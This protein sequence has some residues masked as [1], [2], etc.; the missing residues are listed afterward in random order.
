MMFVSGS[1]RGP[2]GGAFRGSTPPSPCCP[3]PSSLDFWIEIFYNFD[4]TKSLV[5][6]FIRGR[7]NLVLVTIICITILPVAIPV[8]YIRGCCRSS[9]S[10]PW[11]RG[12]MR[13]Y[14]RTASL[15]D[16]QYF[17]IIFRGL[18]VCAAFF[19]LLGHHLSPCA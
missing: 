19:R 4:I 7:S 1:N 13:N 3:N 11:R 16:Y 14:G 9:L 12:G 6:I 15:S 2:I 8:P 17:N 10:G 18:L 5:I